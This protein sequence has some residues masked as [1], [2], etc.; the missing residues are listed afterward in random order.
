MATQ[1]NKALIILRRKQVE[2]RTG[3]SRSSLYKHMSEGTFPAQIKLGAR[4]VG[5]IESEVT[6][7]LEA[8]IS[9][10]RAAM[11]GGAA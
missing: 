5:W 3:Y 1:L 6:A 4:A 11:K 2:A 9:E 7:F 10:S 8:R